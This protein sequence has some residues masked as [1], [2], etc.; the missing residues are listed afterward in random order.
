MLAIDVIREV[1]PAG[2]FLTHKHT[3][4]H[5]RQEL[6]QPKHLNRDSPR[7]WQEKGSKRY[8]EIVTQKAI[9]ILETYAPEPLPE[10]VQKKINKIASKAEKEM[11]DMQ[12]VA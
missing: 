10:N 4:T 6:W 2:N 7:A 3:S 12:F 11:A 5:Y 1:G 9:E 8:E